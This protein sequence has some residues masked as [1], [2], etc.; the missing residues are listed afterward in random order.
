MV[1]ASLLNISASVFIFTIFFSS[2]HYEESVMK[3]G[4]K[5]LLWALGVLVLLVGGLF[6]YLYPAMKPMMSI[7]EIRTTDKL[8][9]VIGGGGNSGILESENL[10]M[11][12]DTKMGGSAKELYALAKQKAGKRPILVVNTHVHG[13]HT[14]GN[15]YYTGARI[16]A[17]TY[18]EKLWREQNGQENMPTEWLKDSI[19]IPMDDEMVSIVNMGQAH[20]FSDVV[21]YF[22]KR[23]MLFAGDLIQYKMHPFL[24]PVTGCKALNYSVALNR[25]QKTFDIQTLVPGHGPTGG[26]ELLTTFQ[27]Y[28]RDMETIAKD[29]SRQDLKDQYSDWAALPFFSSSDVTIKHLKAE[30]SAAK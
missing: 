14:G 17:G 5:I 10:L 21:I 23:K 26:M 27:Q 24:N 12:I 7:Q 11:V 4:W 30:L 16:L 22:H 25:I 1:S 15:K 3:K 29:D 8:T 20:T 19:G 9:L 2:S 18:D 13:D 6:V 28:F